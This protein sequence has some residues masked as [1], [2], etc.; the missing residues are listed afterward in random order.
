MGEV[1]I[2]RG[3]KKLSG[4]VLASAARVAATVNST[5]Q[6][7]PHGGIKGA[8]VYLDITAKVGTNP[9]LNVKVQG[10]D[11]LSGQYVDLASA[12]FAEATATSVAMLTIYPG[13]A[14][15]SNVSVSDMLPSIWRIQSASASDT[16]TP[17]VSF[18]YSVAVDYME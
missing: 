13:I 1:N 7:K 6:Y 11:S 17:A 12:A 10:K 15:S 9:T 5:D 14:E 8:R 18:T 2:A 16:S 3:P 4:A